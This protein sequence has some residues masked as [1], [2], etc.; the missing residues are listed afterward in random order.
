MKYSQYISFTIFSLFLIACSK[1]D[2]GE[3]EPTGTP[4]SFSLALEENVESRAI[5]DAEAAAAL[6]NSFKVWGEKTVAGN[7][8]TV[9]DGYTVSYTNG[10]WDYISGSQTVKYWDFSASKYRFNAIAPISN[11]TQDATEANTF[12]ANVRMGKEGDANEST[13]PIHAYIADPKVIES[14]GYGQKVTLSFR[15]ILSKVCLKFYFSQ[16]F[17]DDQTELKVYDIKFAPTGEYKY[18]KEDVKLTYNSSSYSVTNSAST[19]YSNETLNFG[20]ATIKYPGNL[21]S[22]AGP[23]DYSYY[24]LPSLSGVTPWQVSLT[25]KLPPDDKENEQ[26]AVVPASFMEWKP[27]YTYTY[28]F[29]ITDD[30]GLISVQFLGLDATITPWNYGGYVIDNNT[31]TW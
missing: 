9:F 27:G 4:I 14:S 25:L 3:P 13:K 31:A 28:L 5:T 18:M 15:D 23:A 20:N 17:R 29:K 26:T 30:G 7:T 1:D 2:N 24:M 21:S 6:G 19:Q 16:K 22:Q 12:V 10:A 8:Q 11:F